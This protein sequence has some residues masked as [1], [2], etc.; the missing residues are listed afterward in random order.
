MGLS[1]SVVLAMHAL[2][3]HALGLGRMQASAL[4]GKPLD[5]RV[6][7]LLGNGET[8]ESR[9]VQVDSFAGDLRLP[10][11]TEINATGNDPHLRVRSTAA[12]NDPV[13][14]VIVSVGCESVQTRRYTLLVEPSP[15][16]ATQRSSVS[17]NAGAVAAAT[18]NPTP[19]LAAQPPTP[20]P[21]APANPAPTAQALLSATALPNVAQQAYAPLLLAPASP[22]AARAQR[23]LKST[24]PPTESAPK[25][26][27]AQRDL[28]PDAAARKPTGPARP[29]L[30]VEPFD[31][32]PG[33]AA[34]TG[35]KASVMLDSQPIATPDQRAALTALW[36]SLQR[37]PEEQ[38]RQGKAQ[39][40]LAADVKALRADTARLAQELAR[41][42]EERKRQDRT[43]IWVALGLVLLAAL[44]ATGFWY[45]QRRNAAR[46]SPWWGGGQASSGIDDTEDVS[47]ALRRG[48]SQYKAQLRQAAETSAAA[49]T[50]GALVDQAARTAE[51]EATLPRGMYFQDS[52]ATDAATEA[53]AMA[54]TA[55]TA[56][57]AASTAAL[58]PMRDG[59]PKS[60]LPEFSLSIP[61]H[62]SL[63]SAD[64]VIDVNQQ[65]EFFISLGQHQQAIELLREHIDA[66]VDPAPL[67]FVDLLSLYHQTKDEA[68]FAEMRDRFQARFNAQVPDFAEFGADKRGLDAYPRA[69]ERI[70]ALWPSQKVVRVI[71]ESLLRKPDAE[72]K[73]FTLQAYR[74]LLFLHDLLRSESLDELAVDLV[75]PSFEETR[76]RPLSSGAPNP[77][78]G[79]SVATLAQPLD[80]DSRVSVASDSVMPSMPIKPRDVP[81]PS[82]RL[83][84]DIDLAVF[85]DDPVPAKSPSFQPPQPKPAPERTLL[86]PPQVNA[87]ETAELSTPPAIPTPAKPALKKLP[88]TKPSPET[89]QLDSNW[90]DFDQVTSA[91]EPQMAKTSAAKAARRSSFGKDPK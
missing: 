59:G 45:W 32:S 29:R 30:V 34:P 37:A 91:Y 3:A 63:L 89:A 83:G 57:S 61:G 75:M 28:R 50:Q 15:E 6:S 33:A 20:A 88:P 25:P 13:V 55:A 54:A 70:Q 18:A 11:L 53:K 66:G 72:Q 22:R 4:L 49:S 76:I 7:L 69:L 80:A 87:A 21:T 26:A 60:M 48:A 38:V 41:V 74:D 24:E 65:A 42:Q 40:Q 12:L 73:P 1:V 16:E 82:P 36:Q 78:F 23:N 19:A 77:A 62:S 39:E 71:E 10:V 81:R 47:S 64:E 5:A 51:S 68:A 56:A 86:D 35:L 79:V 90:L 2:T 8:L 52:F 85:D 31:L 44:G 27:R 58:K 17:L 9:C 43:W 67:L 84:I 14:T 46:R